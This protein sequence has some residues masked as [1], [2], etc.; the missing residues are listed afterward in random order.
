MKPLD[1]IETPLVPDIVIQYN[2]L[3]LSIKVQKADGNARGIETLFGR[4]FGAPRECVRRIKAARSGGS[5]SQ[6]PDV[7]LLDDISG[8]ILPGRLTLV[9][10]APG[11]CFVVAS[12]FCNRYDVEL[13][14]SPA[15]DTGSGKS[16][17][18]KALTN[19]LANPRKL[20]GTVRYSGLTATEAAA[21]CV[22]DC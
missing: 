15:R 17:Y 20:K 2:N 8:Y 16:S 3:S 12:S 6:S 13:W 22:C 19:R 5:S 9:L 7:M 4:M 14:C 21:K 11:Q 18:L 10:G 1:P